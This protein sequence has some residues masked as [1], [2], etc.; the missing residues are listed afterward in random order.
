M[1]RTACIVIAMLLV[2]ACAAGQQV[3]TASLTTQETGGQYPNEMQGHWRLGPISAG[4]LPAQG[5]CQGR[6]YIRT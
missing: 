5:E 3:N 6:T 4:D 1:Q 2:S